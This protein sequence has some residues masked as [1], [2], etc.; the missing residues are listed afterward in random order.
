MPNGDG[1]MPPTFPAS[2]ESRQS[3]R[4]LVIVLMTISWEAGWPDW[5]IF[6]RR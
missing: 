1:H 4:L 5:L 2:P 3:Q 6:W